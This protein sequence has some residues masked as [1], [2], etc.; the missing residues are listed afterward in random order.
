VSAPRFRLGEGPLL[1]AAVEQVV[2]A[3]EELSR[4]LGYGV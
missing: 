2:A 4:D 3:G 1:E